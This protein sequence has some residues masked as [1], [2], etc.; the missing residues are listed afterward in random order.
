MRRVYRQPKID[1][2]ALAA[3]VDLI[4]CEIL[5]AGRDADRASRL[6]DVLYNLNLW[7]GDRMLSRR[8]VDG[9]FHLAIHSGLESHS[10]I[11]PLVAEKLWEVCWHF[12]GPDEVP[13][14]KQDERQ[15]L[16]CA[17]A[18]GTLATFTCMSGQGR[19]A[20]RVATEQAENLFQV[21]LWYRRERII[22]TVLDLYPKASE[23]CGTRWVYGRQ[24]LS[25]SLRR[26][27]RLSQQENIPRR[28]RELIRRQGQ[29][30]RHRHF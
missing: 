16:R 1:A 28:I 12:V 25:R 29:A 18:L 22:K 13:M 27:M 21:G 24:T 26:L 9:L 20:I 7:R 23:E 14:D 5:A 4:V 10:V 30:R 6:L 15:V 17:E 11:S 19:R 8:I 3:Q 2:Q